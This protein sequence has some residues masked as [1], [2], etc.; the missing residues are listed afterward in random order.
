M[1]GIPGT[2]QGTGIQGLRNAALVAVLAATAVT[3]PAP[4]ASAA[5]VLLGLHAE[6]A[7][8]AELQRIAQGGADLLRA[9]IKWGHVQPVKRGPYNWI[10]YDTLIGDA[11]LAGIRVLPVVVGSPRYARPGPAEQPTR[12]RDLAQFTKFVRKLAQRYGPGGKFW[13]ARP[14]I[15][16]RPVSAWQIWNEPNLSHYWAGSPDPE[17]YAAF[18]ERT[19]AAIHDSQPDAKIV[20]AGMPEQKARTSGSRF[21]EDLYAQKGFSNLFDAAA[22]HAYSKRGTGPLTT[23]RRIRGVMTRNGDPRKPIWVTELGWGTA[24]PEGDPRVTTFDGQAANLSESFQRLALQADRLRLASIIWYDWRDRQ[25]TAVDIDHF[26]FHTGLFSREGEPKPAWPVFA[27]LAKG[28]PGSGPLPDETP[29]P[30]PEPPA[31]PP[32]PPAP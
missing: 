25:P 11:A 3:A 16:P 29:E 6:S 20:L 9:P 30:E 21:L 24:G 17:E 19:A 12:K 32:P 5:E 2:A 13:I 14:E 7:T 31:E 23:V 8:P 15:P 18:L 26:S 28:D 27:S 10:E 22:V 4:A 1:T